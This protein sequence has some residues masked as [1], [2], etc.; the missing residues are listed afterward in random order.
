MKAPESC[1][2][3]GVCSIKQHGAIGFAGR[4][5]ETIAHLQMTSQDSLLL[6]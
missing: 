3:L 1:L 4:T 6:D 5:R 2:V